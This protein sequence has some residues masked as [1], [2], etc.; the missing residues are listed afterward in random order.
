MKQTLDFV[1]RAT[2]ARS[3][4]VSPRRISQYVDEGRLSRR[5]DG[6]YSLAE[7]RKLMA[8]GIDHER[9]EARLGVRSKATKSANAARL[10][11]LAYRA[12]L[13]ELDYRQQAGE[14]VSKAEAD[15]AANTIMGLI[16]RLAHNVEARLAPHVNDA[17]RVVLSRE[18]ADIL[19]DTRKA[20]ADAS[21]RGYAD[22]DSA[23]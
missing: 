14:L 13:T 23:A 20:L 1:N 22:I 17:G 4:G 2:L 10:H 19:R 18:I 9:R 21:A 8:D 12:K 6:L 5:A 3:L 15:I 16:D 11:G 7:G